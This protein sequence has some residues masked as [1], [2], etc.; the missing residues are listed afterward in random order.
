MMLPCSADFYR[1][2]FCNGHDII[3]LD[4]T[5][6]IHVFACISC[7]VT[8]Y[9]LHATST[10]LSHSAGLLHQRALHACQMHVR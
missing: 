9:H 7:D 1:H 3:T 4:Y 6:V 2:G 5:L 8:I 10:C